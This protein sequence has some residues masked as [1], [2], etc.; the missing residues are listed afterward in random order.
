MEK[1]WVEKI[2]FYRPEGQ[3]EGEIIF[4]YSKDSTG[5][6]RVGVRA[7]EGMFW[8]FNVATEGTEGTE[9]SKK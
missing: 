8:L 9:K 4:T 6:P 5:A 1:D 7:T 2:E 3:K